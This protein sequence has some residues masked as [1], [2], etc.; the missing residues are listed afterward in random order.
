MTLSLGGPVNEVLAE[1]ERLLAV[2][3]EAVEP[4]RRNATR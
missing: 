3:R 4:L 1:R 2:L